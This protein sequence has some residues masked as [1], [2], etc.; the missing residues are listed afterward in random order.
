MVPNWL[1][2]ASVYMKCSTDYSNCQGDITVWMCSCMR[3][4][5]EQIEGYHSYIP[6][7]CIRRTGIRPIICHLT[8]FALHLG[9]G[10][11]CVSSLNDGIL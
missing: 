9:W 8:L 10:I 11:H 2:E 7:Y 6:I 5:T 1:W 4:A 3:N